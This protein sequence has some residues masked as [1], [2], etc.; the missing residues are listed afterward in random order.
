MELSRSDG[1]S[2]KSRERYADKGL[3][4]MVVGVV[5]VVS[6]PQEITIFFQILSLIVNL[7]SSEQKIGHF[8]RRQ[9]FQSRSCRTRSFFA[10]LPP[11]LKWPQ[12][13]L[14]SS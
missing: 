11:L 3:C 9:F 1:L 5:P 14:L 6:R 13:A 4:F 2:L 7:D 12:W 10:L 8:K